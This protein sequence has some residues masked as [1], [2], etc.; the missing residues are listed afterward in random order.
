V[1]GIKLRY[2][3]KVTAVKLHFLG[4]NRQVTGSRYVLEACGKRIMVDCGMFQE[5]EFAQRNWNPCPIEASTVDALL[6]THAHIDHLGLIPRFAQ[7]G[8]RGPILCTEPTVDLAEI[9]LLDAAKIQQEDARYKRRRHEKEGRQGPHPPQALF[10]SEEANDCLRQF[11]RVKYGSAVKLGENLEAIFYDAGHILGSASIELRVT[12]AGRSQRVLFSG[13]IGQRD[14]PL[15]NDP[16]HFLQADYIVLESTYGDRDH[17]E[18]GDISQQLADVINRTVQRKGNVVIPTF[19]VERAQEIIYFI[20]RLV[21]AG[22]IPQLRVFLDSPMAVD[23]TEIFRKYRNYFDAE[24]WQLILAGDSPLHFAGLR[25]A[26]DSAES[27]KINDYDQPAIIMATSGMCTGGRIKHHLRKNIGRAE[28]TI[29]FVGYQAAH[30]LGRQIL[31]RPAHVRIHGRD[32]AVRAEVAQL[33]GFS[34]HADRTALLDWVDHFQDDPERV[35]LTHGDQ[36]AAESLAAAIRQRR[37]WKV[38]IPQY[39]ETVELAAN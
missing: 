8:F 12:E 26:R 24:A 38:H 15:I 5:R 10:S 19:A 1:R 3:Q 29:L 11:Q 27:K 25:M 35:F 20:A 37:N 6:L 16:T 32:Y 23:V 18:G 4:A 34:G 31:N 22:R 2:L 7:Q 21:E 30:T 14:R 13:D 39:G 17:A 33:L 36:E 9:M 28:S